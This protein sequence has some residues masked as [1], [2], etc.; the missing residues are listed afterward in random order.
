LFAD[1]IIAVDPIN[2]QIA[3]RLLTALGSWR[4]FDPARQ[5]LMR[6]ALQRILDIENLSHNSF[7]MASKSL[8]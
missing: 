4:R 7:E 6:A 8:G 3:A 1:I 2:P 5:E